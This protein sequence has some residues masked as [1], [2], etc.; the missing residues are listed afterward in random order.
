MWR[1][2]RGGLGAASTWYGYSGVS[3]PSTPEQNRYQATAETGTYDAILKLKVF[4]VFHPN[5]RRDK[6]YKVNML[7]NFE[8][9]DAFRNPLELKQANRKFKTPPEK[10][11]FPMVSSYHAKS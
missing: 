11:S 2:Y 9:Y 3:V 4:K 8:C 10:S 7:L 6:L 1:W 5:G